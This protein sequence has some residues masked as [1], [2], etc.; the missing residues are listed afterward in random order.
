VYQEVRAH[1]QYWPFLRTGPVCAV[2]GYRNR[3]RL[4][5]QVTNRTFMPVPGCPVCASSN[6]VSKLHLQTRG[7]ATAPRHRCTALRCMAHAWRMRC[8]AHTAFAH[9]A[10]QLEV[11]A[12]PRGEGPG[13]ARARASRARA[14]DDDG[15]HVRRDDADMHGGRSGHNHRD[16]PANPVHGLQG[17]PRRADR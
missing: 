17:H 8:C 10:V 14:A 12:V 9:G 1:R 13:A 5:A 15:A 16:L 6:L 3:P 11:R 4:S 2:A 7:C